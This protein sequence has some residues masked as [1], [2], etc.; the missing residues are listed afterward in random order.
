[1]EKKIKILHV[2]S[3]STNRAS[4]TRVVVPKHFLHQSRH[5]ETAILNCSGNIIDELKNEKNVYYDK[6]CDIQKVI[7]S[8]GKPDIIVF[9]E[10]YKPV[11]CSAVKELNIPYI[12]IPHGCLTKG[13]QNNKPLKKIIGN[14]LMFNKFI[15]NA[16]AV[17]FLSTQEQDETKIKVQGSFIMGNGMEINSSSKDKKERK[18]SKYTIV[19]I[20]RLNVYHKG[21]DF[22]LNAC[23]K[24]VNK[25]KQNNIVVKLY[26]PASDEDEKIIN[27]MLSDLNLSDVVEIFPPIFDAEKKAVLE[28][29]DIF[30]QTS[31]FEGQPLGVMEAMAN[32]L[33]IIVTPGTSF[34]GVVNDVKCG[35]VAQLDSESI[36]DAIIKSFENREKNIDYGNNA[37]V[38]AC[39]NFE[40]SKV[41]KKT[42]D[43]YR[44]I[45]TG[46][47]YE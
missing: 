35:Y 32:S 14:M 18:N 6:N 47:I 7:E 20:G 9:H 17:Q 28:S 13:A 12:I 38:Y 36:A 25:M 44:K 24:I 40:W 34:D 41:A 31:R 37:Y 42:I 30:I 43:V 46:E 5:T 8:F 3:I 26:G 11:Y 2:C 33:P 29:A 23:S 1:M 27:K 22:L 19:Y 45:A 10:V 16:K 15:K 21:L 39:E 4:G